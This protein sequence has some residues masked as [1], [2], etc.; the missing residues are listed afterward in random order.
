MSRK[1]FFDSVY[2]PNPPPPPTGRGQPWPL[3]S[4]RNPF[5]LSPT[6][7]PLS[8]TA[9]GTDKKS[10]LSSLFFNEKGRRKK[11]PA[12]RKNLSFHFSFSLS[13]FL[14]LFLSPTSLKL[15]VVVQLVDVLVLAHRL[16]MIIF[17]NG[18]KK[19]EREREVERR[20]RESRKKKPRKKK[21]EKRKKNIISLLFTCSAL[22]FLAVSVA[23]PTRISRLVPA[24]PLNAVRPVNFSTAGGAAARAPK[25]AEPRML[26]LLSVP[27]MCSAVALPG[28]TAGMLA[29]CFL[30]CSARSAGSSWRKV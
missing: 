2:S 7:K 4:K 9:P 5:S 8:F 28:R 6:I 17:V 14:S 13:L 1:F 10:K 22:T 11:K 26:I 19:T 25:N 3:Q 23:T 21:T 27:V 30:S 20:E 18:E 16:V 29:P 12:P 24:K 15:Q